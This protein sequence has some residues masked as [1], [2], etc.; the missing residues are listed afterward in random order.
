MVCGLEG[1]YLVRALLALLSSS[2]DIIRYRCLRPFIGATIRLVSAHSALGLRS[3]LIRS[4]GRAHLWALSREIGAP[5]GS[6]L[7]DWGA[8][9]GSK[10]GDWGASLGPELGDWDASLGFSAGRLERL[11]ALTAVA[12]WGASALRAGRL[13]RLSA[14]TALAD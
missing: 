12:D 13:G 3:Q 2:V 14:L 11:S 1:L 7:G 10:P 5:L 6:E 8:S 4:E 9:L